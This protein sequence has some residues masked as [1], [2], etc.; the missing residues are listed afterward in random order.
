MLIFSTKL[1]VSD[2]LTEERLI[3][4]VIT[5]LNDNRNYHFHGLAYNGEENY[6][7]DTGS[8]N[9]E[10]V[11][12]PEALIIRLVS[13]SNGVIW[14]NDYALKKGSGTKILAIQLYS[15][16]E[17]LSVRIPQTFNK[18]RLLRQ[19]VADG[20]GGMDHDIVVS[21]KPL[22]ITEENI[23]LAKNL[24]LRKT[25]YCMPVVYVTFPRYAIDMPIDY[26]GLALNLAGIAHVA[27]ETKEIAPS[28]RKVTNGANPYAGAVEIF[29]GSNSSY[30]ML[31]DDYDTL[32]EMQA[33]IE[34]TVQQR[35]LMTKIDDDL[36]WN[37]IRFTHI[38]KKSEQDPELTEIY[39]QLLKDEKEQG[40]YKDQHIEELELHTMEL[41]E[42]IKDLNAELNNK[43][44][45]I[46][47]YQYMLGH[48]NDNGANGITLEISERELYEGEIKD[49]VL[50]VLEK[51]KGQ[52]DGDLNLKA[53]R[54]F[55]VLS[56]IVSLNNQT[57]KAE[58][59]SNWLKEIIDASGNLNAQ[60]KRELIEAGFKI[61]TGTHYKI[62]YN[63]DGR[64][65]FTL[66]K[67]P[68]DYRTNKNT[69][70][71]ATATLFGR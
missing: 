31:P 41:E 52:L 22:L 18:P 58:E 42:R 17:N 44:S 61:E 9:L 47:S 51:E 48:K 56:D 37:K 43:E 60:R 32:G 53:S 2:A 11:Q 30:R 3:Q 10:I 49:V 24:I 57:G 4:Y 21:N 7:V 55:H 15:D 67:T 59:I 20:Y 8:E 1:V 19:I 63:E 35:L 6:I 36:S 29:Y 71:D 39:E 54:K 27:V 12:Y 13:Y 68:G 5:W 28:V 26:N 38:Q 69:L 46:Q 16:A 62:T 66:A 25:S 23:E 65:T 50:R 14:T 40:S 45:R 34:K 64:Y 33:A 70:K